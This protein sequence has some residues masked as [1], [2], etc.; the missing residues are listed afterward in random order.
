MIFRLFPI[1]CVYTKDKVLVFYDETYHISQEYSM[2]Q[3]TSFVT[4]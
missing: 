2:Y 4:T 1:L 3:L